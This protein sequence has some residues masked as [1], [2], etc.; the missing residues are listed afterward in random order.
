MKQSLI[1]GVVVAALAGLS[2][3]R[4]VSP[5]AVQCPNCGIGSLPKQ[6]R[7]VLELRMHDGVCKIDMKTPPDIRT[8]SGAT[9]SWLFIGGCANAVTI[10]IDSSVE[11]KNGQK[12]SFFDLKDKGTQLQRK[13]PPDGNGPPMFLTGVIG[14][15]Q[16]GGRYKYTVLIDNKPA[17]YNSNADK[18]DFIVCPN[19]P[20]GDFENY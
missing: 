11:D 15:I 7:V 16:A 2:A 1:V 17:Q 18:G 20:C 8:E 10:A 6:E 19:W 12:H 13:A 5:L 4:S 9:V 3:C 14:P